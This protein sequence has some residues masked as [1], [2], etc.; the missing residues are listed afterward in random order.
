MNSQLKLYSMNYKSALYHSNR[1]IFL[2]K[3]KECETN[4]YYFFI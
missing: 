1:F 3:Q 4:W 2:N